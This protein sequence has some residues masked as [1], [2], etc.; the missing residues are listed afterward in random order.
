MEMHGFNKDE[1]LLL[2]P[3]LAY[4][5][6][7]PGAKKGIIDLKEV[8]STA[9]DNVDDADKFKNFVNFFEAILAYHRAAGGR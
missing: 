3:K 4:A 5:A 7:K 8:L 6:A 2:K 9:I 1:L